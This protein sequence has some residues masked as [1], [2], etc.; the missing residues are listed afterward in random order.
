LVAAL[1]VALHACGSEPAYT[2]AVAPAAEQG[3]DGDGPGDASGKDGGAS[4]SMP[5]PVRIDRCGDGAELKLSAD[6]LAK[7]KAGGSAS[8]MRFLYP[9][10]GTVFP[11]GLQAPAL[12]WEGA[13]SE[14]AELIYVH[15]SSSWFDYQGCLKPDAKGRITL[16][17]DIWEKAGAQTLGKRDPFKLELSTLRAG[18]VKGPLAQEIVIAPGSLKGSVFYNSYSSP[19]A[20]LQGAAGGAVLRIPAGGEAEVFL[21]KRGCVGCHSVS[22]Q[23]NRLVAGGDG[24]L[25]GV[26][27]LEADGPSNPRSLGRGA[28]FVGLYPDGSVYL[29]TGGNL[30]ET[31]TQKSSQLPA[32]LESLQMPMFAPDGR[33]AVYLNT[34]LTPE[35]SENSFAIESSLIVVPYEHAKRKFGQPQVRVRDASMWQWPSFLP[36]SN[37]VVVANAENDLV[38][39]NADG[40]VVSLTRAMGFAKPE[41]AKEN[42]TY[43]TGGYADLHAHFYP[44]V[45][46]VA[47]GGYFWVFFDSPRRYGNFDTS[48]NGVV[49]AQ[50]PV[51]PGLE[52]LGDL[53]APPGNQ[54]SSRQLWAFAIEISADGRYERDPS[55]PAFYLPGQEMGSNNHRAFAALDPCHDDGA[56]CSSGTACCGGFCTDG[57]CTVPGNACAKTEEACTSQ[58]DC[59]NTEDLCLNGFCSVV[60]Q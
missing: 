49:A 45:V 12:M 38:L 28:E 53:V 22:A 25:E 7:L 37:T 60:L 2:T 36:D 13:S 20:R 17:Q 14:D 39:V 41:D 4:A 8:G 10:A 59:C 50:I 5:D 9:Y 51:I 35:R 54:G 18:V 30:V 58:A 19:L 16:P 57:K 31:D 33:S 47:A 6:Q 32:P 26:Y 23:G 11:R 46:P 15:V 21:G 24:E 3:P 27:A 55:A 43:L 56:A 52:W 1:V 44:T 29:A 42:K 40:S 48:P 34:A